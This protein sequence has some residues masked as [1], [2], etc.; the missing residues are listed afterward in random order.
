MQHIINIKS[1]KRLNEKRIWVGHTTWF[2]FYQ[3]ELIGEFRF[4][5]CESSRWLLDNGIAHLEDE[6]IMERSSGKVDM[7][8]IVGK[9][10]LQTVQETESGPRFAKWKPF[11][12][13]Y[14]EIKEAAE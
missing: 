7:K 8:G 6:I 1:A 2:V 3:S 11:I 4:P 9:L 14:D 10:A 12:P 5:M 13:L